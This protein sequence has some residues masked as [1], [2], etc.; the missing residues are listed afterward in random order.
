MDREYV[1]MQLE[2]VFNKY[3]KIQQNF[4][5]ILTL[6]REDLK[7]RITFSDLTA[8]DSTAYSAYV[9]LERVSRGL[10]GYSY[11]LDHKKA[12]TDKLEKVLGKD[13]SNVDLENN[14]IIFNISLNDPDIFAK[15]ETI[16][17]DLIFFLED[18]PEHPHGCGDLE[19]GWN[20]FRGIVYHGSNLVD[21]KSNRPYI[22]L[23]QTPLNHHMEY[24][25]RS[26]STSCSFEVAK[27]F[28][29]IKNSN[30]T[31]WG[32]IIEYMLQT[33]R[34]YALSSDESKSDQYK[35]IDKAEAV[36]IPLGN[37][38]EHEIAVLNPRVLTAKRVFITTDLKNYKAF[39]I[40]K[41]IEEKE[42]LV[43]RLTFFKNEMKVNRKEKFAE[44]KEKEAILRQAG[45][46][47][48][49]DIRYQP[50]KNYI[51]GEG[52][53]YTIDIVWEDPK[54]DLDKYSDLFNQY[55]KQHNIPIITW[56]SFYKIFFEFDDLQLMIEQFPIINQIYHQKY[57]KEY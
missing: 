40:P 42:A 28:V 49:F 47:Y 25:F 20:I 16:L 11:E 51:P 35:Q 55:F 41:S 39:H 14:Y 5:N 9:N 56:A 36:A 13:L 26:I 19:P 29:S 10:S 50:P 22:H 43:E 31:P 34:L 33:N 3:F 8:F 24:G 37:F 32:Y 53:I 57:L 15:L 18:L 52:Y 30:I 17:P 23:F 1:L 4:D 2:D 54:R 7:G 12:L 46:K 21:T 27:H 48:N 44:I 38:K 6:R 45:K